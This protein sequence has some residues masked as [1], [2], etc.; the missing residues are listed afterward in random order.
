MRSGAQLQDVVGAG[1]LHAPLEGPRVFRGQ[2]RGAR[3]DLGQSVDWG[4]PHASPS[5]K[6]VIT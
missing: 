6:R 5:P 4:S 3:P 2:Q 1:S